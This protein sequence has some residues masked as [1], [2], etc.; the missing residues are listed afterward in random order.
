MTDYN[1]QILLS[2]SSLDLLHSTKNK[3]LQS[4]RCFEALPYSLHVN[5]Y[6]PDMVLT[7]INNVIDQSDNDE[8]P[9]FEIT[10][11]RVPRFKIT[12]R[13]GIEHPTPD[14]T[15]YKYGFPVASIDI[16]RD[17]ITFSYKKFNWHVEMDIGIHLKM[18]DKSILVVIVD[19]LPG[20]L[21]VFQGEDCLNLVPSFEQ[22][23]V[24]KTENF[25]S[26]RREIIKLF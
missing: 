14:F 23:W 9:S 3:C 20:F 24:M 15:E 8:Y 22:Q 18:I 17:T 10:N 12:D 25:E 13:F 6:F 5:L 2:N 16:I 21:V 7:I 1:F 11:E 4:I 19:S 26:K